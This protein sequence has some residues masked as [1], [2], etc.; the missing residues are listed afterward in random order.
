MMAMTWIKLKK[1]QDNI[2]KIRPTRLRRKL[3]IENQRKLLD[4]L[5]MK[6]R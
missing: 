6:K 3:E 5:K 2:R 4:K 1:V